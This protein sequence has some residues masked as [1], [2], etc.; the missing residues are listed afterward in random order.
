MEEKLIRV[1]KLPE[2]DMFNNIKKTEK[3]AFK[4][5]K[6]CYTSSFSPT[7]KSSC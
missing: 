3:E 5:Q 6:T 7:S 1:R 4:F 2:D